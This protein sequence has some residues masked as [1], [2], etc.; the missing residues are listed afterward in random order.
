MK[1]KVL[2]KDGDETTLFVPILPANKPIYRNNEAYGEHYVMFLPEVITDIMKDANKRSIPFDYEHQGEAVSGV[3]WVSSFQIDYKNK[4]L[5]NTYPG[6]TDG[7]WV[8]IIAI[9]SEFENMVN[10]KSG[11]QGC[12]LDFLG[13]SISGVF[14]YH[15]L[16]LSEAIE[17]YNKLKF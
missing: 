13:I 17:L 1:G 11:G 8:G 16:E 15:K 9:N 4:T 7:T 6:L 12:P 5:Y 14:S 3:E 10:R 2:Y